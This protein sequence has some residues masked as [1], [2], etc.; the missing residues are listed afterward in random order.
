M[1]PDFKI[2]WYMGTLKIQMG[3][4]IK[5]C[6]KYHTASEFSHRYLRN[7][8]LV[9]VCQIIFKYIQLIWHTET[10]TQFLR[11]LWLNSDAVWYFLHFLIFWTHFHF[12]GSIYQLIFKS[13]NIWNPENENKPHILWLGMLKTWKSAIW[14][15]GFPK[16][17]HQGCHIL[18]GR[19]Y[20][21]PILSLFITLI[22]RLNHDIVGT[23][24]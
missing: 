16:F 7:W 12:Q 18:L 17:A 1:F 4:N 23:L 20:P 6:I 24:A 15:S 22:D 5:K 14:F 3:K 10:K 9:S 8:V 19:N 11:D 2:S 13:G 21:G